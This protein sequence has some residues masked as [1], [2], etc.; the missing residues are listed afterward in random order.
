MRLHKTVLFGI[1]A[2]GGAVLAGIATLLL[3]P[4]SGDTMRRQ[5]REQFDNLLDD[6]QSAAE[7]RRAELEAELDA[8]IHP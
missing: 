3:S 6:A 5:A 1:G 4:D 2:L 8:L 7:A